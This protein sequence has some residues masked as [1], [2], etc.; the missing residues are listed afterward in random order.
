M[1]TRSFLPSQRFWSWNC[2]WNRSGLLF[3]VPPGILY[4]SIPTLPIFVKGQTKNG[5]MNKYFSINNAKNLHNLAKKNMNTWI[6][7][8]NPIRIKNK[9][10]IDDVFYAS[11]SKECHVIILVSSFENIW[12]FLTLWINWKVWWV[13]EW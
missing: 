1:E 8:I 6:W 13:T 5:L 10:N 2:F 4:Q 9:K 7:D 3:L 11:S 12:R